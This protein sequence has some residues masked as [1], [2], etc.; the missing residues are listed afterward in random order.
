VIDNLA[1]YVIA[2]SPCDEAIQLVALDCFAEPVIGPAKPD[3]LARKDETYRSNK[4]PGREAGVLMS[5]LRR[6]QYFATTG[7]L[8]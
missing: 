4:Y 3:P 2:R 1:E 8:K 7:E 5:A 6:D